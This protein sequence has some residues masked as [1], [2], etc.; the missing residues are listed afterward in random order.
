[1]LE[2]ILGHL[3]GNPDPRILAT[4][5]I[6]LA[7]LVAMVKVNTSA[8]VTGLFLAVEI[9]A[10]VLISI[11]GFLHMERPFSSLFTSPMFL[12]TATNSLSRVPGGIIM[13]ATAIAL[14]A[15]NGYGAAAGFGEE[16]HDPKRNIVKVV[17]WALFIIVVFE[18]VPL[19]AVL[20]SAPDLKDLLVAPQKIEYFLEARA[21][22]T[23]T[24][25][26]SLVI[27]LAIFNAVIAIIMQT[28]RYLFSSGR[29]KTWVS[30]S[31]NSGLATISKRFG[32]PWISTA[33]VALLSG[34]ASFIDINYLLVATSATLVVIYALLCIAVIVGRNNKST[35]IGIYRMPFF[36][37]P[38]IIAL[39]FLCY[40]TYETAQDAAIGMPSLIAAAL[41]VFIYAVYYFIFLYRRTDWELHS[42][43]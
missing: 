43:K 31:L 29:D 39:L 5:T 17:L 2:L 42:L 14:F 12:D 11:L 26:T 18:I 4:V 33:V 16:T 40:I 23:G 1:M 6:A 10:L 19:T 36:P 37:L 41:L 24:I 15:Y 13:A 38:A 8:F 35:S 25:I 32:S 20:L 21:G 27:A 28:A 9:F 3:L 22:H 30:N 34:A 7:A